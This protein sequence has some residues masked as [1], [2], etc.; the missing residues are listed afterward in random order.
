MSKTLQNTMFTLGIT[1]CV[2][3]DTKHGVEIKWEPIIFGKEPLL[4]SPSHK[5]FVIDLCH[6]SSNDGTLINSSYLSMSSPFTHLGW[7]E[8]P[9]SIPFLASTSISFVLSVVDCLQTISWTPHI[10]YK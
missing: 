6:S 3:N 9:W 10:I 2:A 8:T 1:A 7:H 5:S 4:H